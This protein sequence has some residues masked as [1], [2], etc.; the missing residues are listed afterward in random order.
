MADCQGMKPV[1]LLTNDCSDADTDSDTDSDTDPDESELRVVQGA[2]CMD[3][4]W[5][6]AVNNSDW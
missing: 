4:T 2:G 3:A 1:Q 6:L 5:G